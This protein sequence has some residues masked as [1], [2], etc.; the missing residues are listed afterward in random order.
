MGICLRTWF[1]Q[2]HTRGIYVAAFLQSVSSRQ[3][4][5]YCLYF[6]LPCSSSCCL[7]PTLLEGLRRWHH[8]NSEKLLDLSLFRN[9]QITNFMFFNRLGIIALACFFYL[10]RWVTM[11]ECCGTQS[12]GGSFRYPAGRR[13]N[14]YISSLKPKQSSAWAR[15]DRPSSGAG[16][17]YL[18]LG[19]W[20]CKDK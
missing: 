11:S 13:D 9:T 19:P 4:L 7:P 18:A 1:F 2:N 3:Q 16:V 12:Q 6:V 17:S 5:F 8:S 14:L 10:P 20:S 15:P